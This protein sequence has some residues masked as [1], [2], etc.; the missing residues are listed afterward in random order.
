MYAT[1][2]H[3]I[4]NTVHRFE[5]PG[6]LDH[7]ERRLR[8]AHA[9]HMG[10]PYNLA[11][12]TDRLQRFG[13][14]LINNL[15]DPYA[16]S[17]YAS[18]VCALEREAISWFER[19]WECDGDDF[20]GSIGASGTEGNLWAIYLGREALPGAVLVHADEAHYSIP[21]AARILNMKS[22][23]VPCSE[24]GAISLTD[25]ADALKRLKGRPIV[26]AL[27]CGTTMK[28][29]HDDIAGAIEMMEAVGF[30]EDRRFIHVDGA[31]NAMVV[32]FAT[33]APAAIRPSFRMRI[34]S[35]S[36]S[37]HKMVGTPMPCGVLVARRKHVTRV[38]SAI[39]YLRSNDTTLMGSRNGH[40]VLS[41]WD[42]VTSHGV[43][44]FTADVAGCLLRT[45]QL[46]SEL[47]RIG[48]SVLRNPLSLTTVFPIPA[49]EIVKTYQLA[50]AKGLAHAIVMP[51]VSEEL[52]GRFIADYRAWWMTAKQQAS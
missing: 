37:G 29:A 39:S 51:N 33:N 49:E 42:R 15:G 32:P 28:G 5:P 1:T 25:L 43:A 18:E 50:C 10:Y 35:V 34:D 4:E 36:T 19:L 27:T 21:K 20:W 23:S 11:F 13:G 2:T 9:N 22:V 8:I 3:A 46:V 6:T 41:I 12:S 31:L 17:H 38:A 16:G 14:Y 24:D 48:V 26:L 30:H 44:G 47:R 52:I 40:A 7:T 45:E